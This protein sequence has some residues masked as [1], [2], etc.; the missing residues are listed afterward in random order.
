MRNT[1]PSGKNP[2]STSLGTPSSDDSESPQTLGNLEKMDYRQRWIANV[3]SQYNWK[4][5]SEAEAM[6]RPAHKRS[7]IANHWYVDG[8]PHPYFLGIHMETHHL[9]SSKGAHVD[10]DTAKALVKAG[11]VIDTLDNLVGLPATLPGACHLGLQAHRGEHPDKPV[12]SK[13]YHTTVKN[14]LEKVKKQLKRCPPNTKASDKIPNIDDITN[15]ISKRLLDKI[16]SNKVALTNIPNN[17]SSYVGC[18]GQTSITK[19]RETSERCP[20]GCNHFGQTDRKYNFK[21]PELS[22]EHEIWNNRVITWP[23]G[24][25]WTL[26]QGI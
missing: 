10:K 26:K 12:E 15:K 20:V 19:A 1:K 22:K 8:D 23:K 17:F 3:R 18:R 14:E 16:V 2:P 9:I 21:R 7:Q 25:K 24:D 4:P 11:Y 6:Q 13:A 5:A